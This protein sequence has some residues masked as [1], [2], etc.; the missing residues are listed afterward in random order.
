MATFNLGPLCVTL[1]FE[2]GGQ[3][4]TLTSCLIMLTFAEYYFIIVRQ[5]MKLRSV[6]AVLWAI[7]ATLNFEVGRRVK[8]MT[9]H[10]MMVNICGKTHA[11]T[12]THAE[13]TYTRQ[14]EC[15][16]EPPKAAK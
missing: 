13:R 9:H 11:H 16:I 2:D 5:M 4:Q 8:H 7:S 14:C 3:F 12:H 1:T 10:L 6:K 15:Y